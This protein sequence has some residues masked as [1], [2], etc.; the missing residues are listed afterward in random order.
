MKTLTA[1]VLIASV[2]LV[3]ACGESKQDKAKKT[4]CNARSDIQDQV[5]KLQGMTLSS[6][7]T[8]EVKDSLNAI[9]DD[10]KKISGAQGDLSDA[11]KAEVHKANQQFSSSFQEIAGSLGSTLSISQARTQIADALKKLG[12]AYQQAFAGVDCS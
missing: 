12:T 11:R 1:I 4:V 8:S 5:K 3:A 10:L 2:A 9:R 7:T 6:A